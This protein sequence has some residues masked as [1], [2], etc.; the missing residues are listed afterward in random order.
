MVVFDDGFGEDAALAGGEELWTA[1]LVVPECEPLDWLSV[2]EQTQARL[3][4]ER[5]RA[6]MLELRA[7]EHRRAEKAS[8]SRAQ[9]YKRQLGAYRIA[10]S[11]HSS[12]QGDPCK[13]S[14]CANL[15]STPTWPLR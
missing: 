5:K 2:L 11:R 14:A 8:R 4:E 6:N 12:H 10:P 15:A 13:R 3:D 7:E 1:P 9:S